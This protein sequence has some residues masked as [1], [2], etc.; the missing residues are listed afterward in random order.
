[1]LKQSRITLPLILFQFCLMWSCLT[2]MTTKSTSARNSS[3]S[4]YWFFCDLVADEER[5]VAFERTCK[6]TFLKLEHLKGWRLTI[7][8][9]I[10][11]ISKT[12]KTNFAVIV[13]IVLLH[14]LVDTVEDKLRLTVVGLHRLRSIT[15]ARRG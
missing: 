10:L 2:I 4:S 3:K 9:D 6:V 15:L 11:F 5:I 12:I 13:D 8:I 1:M 14:D 7:I